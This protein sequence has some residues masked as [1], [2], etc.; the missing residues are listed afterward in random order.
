MSS[1]NFIRHGDHKRINKE[2]LFCGLT[3]RRCDEARKL[4]TELR[5]DAVK[6]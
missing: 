2:L 3:T 4:H 6:S 1:V 5:L